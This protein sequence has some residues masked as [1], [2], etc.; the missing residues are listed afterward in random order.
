M[1]LLPRRIGLRQ[2]RTWFAEAEAQLPEDTLAL[3]HLQLHAMGLCRL[4][5][6]L[7]IRATIADKL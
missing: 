7:T 1:R 3:P 4:T 2:N 6:L 5:C